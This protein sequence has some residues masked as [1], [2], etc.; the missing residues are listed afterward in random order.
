MTNIPDRPAI[1]IGR[2][3]R[4]PIFNKTLEGEWTVNTQGNQRELAY[5]PVEGYSD[6]LLR[7]TTIAQTIAELAIQNGWDR[8][9]FLDGLRLTEQTISG[10][11]DSAFTREEGEPHGTW[12]LI[13]RIKAATGAQ[14]V[15]LMTDCFSKSKTASEKAAE[16]AELAGLLRARDVW[17]CSAHTLVIVLLKRDDGIT[18]TPAVLPDFLA[19]ILVGQGGGVADEGLEPLGPPGV[20]A[21]LINGEQ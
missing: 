2:T 1:A 3:W 10:G 11:R 13:D 21:Q 8:G 20:P 4:G 17:V 14:D 18:A 5:A 7:R 6:R 15:Y 16:L 9:E 12:E 19:V